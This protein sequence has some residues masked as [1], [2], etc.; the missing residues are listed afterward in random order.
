MKKVIAAVVSGLILVGG[1]YGVMSLNDQS[2]VETSSVSASSPLSGDRLDEV[3]RLIGVFEERVAKSEDA[4]NQWTLGAH[5]LDRASITGDVTDYRSARE[6]LE[7]ARLTNSG[8]PSVDIP[9]ASARL[10]LHDFSGAIEVLEPHVLDPTALSIYGDATLGF[11]EVD[12]ARSSYQRLTRIAPDDPAVTVRSA[13]LEWET[14][15]SRAAIDLAAKAAD[16]AADSGLDGRALAF[17]RAYHGLLLFESGQFDDA[18]PVLQAA[19]DLD[20]GFLSPKI[21]LAHVLAARGD[22]DGGIALLEEVLSFGPDADA[23]VVLGDFYTLAG[24]RDSAEASYRLLDEAAARAPEAYRRDVSLFLSNHDRSLDKALELAEAD[25]MTRHDSGAYDTLA[26]ALYRNGRYQEARQASDR[27]IEMGT[28]DAAAHFHAGMI[29]LALGER[30]R[31]AD[32]IRTALEMNS[33]FN[34]LLAQQARTVLDDLSVS[35]SE[36]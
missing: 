19:V 26:W 13:S 22:L 32:E 18:L 28:S 15:E 10:G 34:A 8:N 11:G 27:A 1:S 5:Y 3:D 9:L 36:S 31:A 16:Q 6:I 20:P 4:L 7:R 21:E 24:D 12:E 33:F 14:G 30:A 29:S 23:A 2:S 25:L 17:Y 35:S